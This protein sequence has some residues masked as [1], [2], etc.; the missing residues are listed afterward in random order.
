[1]ATKEVGVGGAGRRGSSRV[2]RERELDGIY[3]T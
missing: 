3:Y 2:W 1:M